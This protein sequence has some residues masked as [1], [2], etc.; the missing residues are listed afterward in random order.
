LPNLLSQIVASTRA[1]VAERKKLLP[2]A[3]LQKNP[4]L[5]NP[6]RDFKKAIQGKDRLHLIAELKRASPSAGV[7]RE[8]FDP[9]ALAKIYD[10]HADAISVLTEEKYFQ[11]SRE[12]LAQVRQ[13][14]NLPLLAKDFF[15][16]PYQIYEAKLAGADA[17]LLIVNI[18]S[19]AELKEF[20]QLAESLSLSALVETHD[21]TEVERALKADAQIIGINNRDLKTFQI[22]LS[23][24]LHLAPKIPAEKILVAESGM[25]QAEDLKKLRG[26][27]DA[28]LIGSAFMREEDVE[29]KIKEIMAA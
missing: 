17:I 23:T 22:D 14:S 8:N 26:V 6:T 5:K 11:G 12:Y 19:D 29:R 24:T 15:T 18:L 20:L 7:I 9:V 21:E 4:A 28:V 27:A 2:L 13:A 25:K 1:A 3:E 10:C 16:D